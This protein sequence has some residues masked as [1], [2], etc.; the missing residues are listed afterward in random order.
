MLT[1]GA[2]AGRPSPGRP[3]TL[4]ERERVR[5]R[6]DLP[7]H[8]FRAGLRTSRPHG[9]PLTA[10][11]APA[12]CRAFSAFLAAFS[13][14]LRLF[15]VSHP[16]P[17]SLTFRGRGVVFTTTVSLRVDLARTR[18]VRF[19]VAYGTLT[20]EI[21]LCGAASAGASARHPASG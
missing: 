8:R 1:A 5:K 9:L 17:A 10:A 20:S 16:P 11:V 13:S 7:V 14:A 3:A 19:T 18:T 12:H 6:H 2:A 15:R 21:R 4:Q